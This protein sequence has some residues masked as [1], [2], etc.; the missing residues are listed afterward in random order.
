MKKRLQ[1]M[2]IGIIIG[3]MLTSG[4]VFAR[5]ISETAE[6]LYDNIKISL[7]GQEILP[8]DANGNYVEPF[9][10]NGTTYT[11]RRGYNIV[12]KNI[13]KIKEILDIN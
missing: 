9:T 3:A 7:N 5:Q 1:G 6:L 10:I 2:I 8:K 4:V 11:A 12:A 13:S